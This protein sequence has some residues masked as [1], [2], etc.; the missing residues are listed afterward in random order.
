MALSGIKVLT[1]AGTS[2]A[3]S[4]VVRTNIYISPFNVSFGV[5]AVSCNYTVQ[6][7]FDDWTRMDNPNTSATWWDHPYVSATSGNATG[8][9]AFPVSMIRVYANSM[10]ATGSVSATFIPAG[11][12]GN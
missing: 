11:I 9:Y 10:D 4:A 12:R 5:V 6:H 7:S 3:T 1:R 8:N 2:G